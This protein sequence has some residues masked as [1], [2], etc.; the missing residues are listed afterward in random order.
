MFLIGDFSQCIIETE[1]LDIIITLLIPLSYNNTN[2]STHHLTLLSLTTL[3][4]HRKLFKFKF[5]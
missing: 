2:Q 1:E 4:S 3:D 5:H